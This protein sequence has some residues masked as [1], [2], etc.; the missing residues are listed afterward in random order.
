[1]MEE[2][3]ANIEQRLYSFHILELDEH[4]RQDGNSGDNTPAFESL[5]KMN[6]KP[7]PPPVMTRQK[8]LEM[9]ELR[10][11]AVQIEQKLANQ[12][13]LKLLEKVQGIV[14]GIEERRSS[15]QAS[16][17]DDQ[18][19]SPEPE[20]TASP[21]LADC[22]PTPDE[23]TNT[24]TETVD[25]TIYR[26][27]G[28][29]LS[30][31][32]TKAPQLVAN[33]AGG[34]SSAQGSTSSSSDASLLNQTVVAAS[35]FSPKD[36]EGT[37]HTPVD[38]TQDRTLT[39]EEKLCNHSFTED[40]AVS[41]ISNLSVP[42]RNIHQSDS[43]SLN[44][45]GR[46]TGTT[47]P[48][49]DKDE[50]NFQHPKNVTV[51]S[52]TS[53]G[54][55]A[56][57]KLACSWNQESR[58]IPASEERFEDENPP[59]SRFHL[60]PS[61]TGSNQDDDDD[62][63]PFGERETY[64]SLLGEYSSLPMPA[65]SSHFF[66][67]VSAAP[68]S[69][70]LDNPS[71]IMI[72]KPSELIGNNLSVKNP[73]KV[74]SPKDDESSMFISTSSTLL[75]NTAGLSCTLPSSLRTVSAASTLQDVDDP[76]NTLIETP[77]PT[78]EDLQVHPE[79]PR[80][81]PVGQEDSHG[82]NPTSATKTIK[83]SPDSAG[84]ENEFI[85][86]EKRVRRNSYTLD[87]PSPALLN[88]QARN[89][90]PRVN[91]GSEDGG[92][93]ARR[94]LELT[95]DSEIEING[96]SK[97]AEVDRVTGSGGQKI[98]LT[99]ELSE[100]NVLQQQLQ[101]FEE[102]RL[103][104]EQQQR[105]QLQQLLM[106]QQ[107]AQMTLQQEMAQLERR[108]QQKQQQQQQDQ[109]TSREED[110]AASR[111]GVAGR[112]EVLV[113]SQGKVSITSTAS[114]GSK[115]STP[116]SAKSSQHVSPDVCSKH[117]SPS[118]LTMV[119]PEV[120]STSKVGSGGQAEPFYLRG[121]TSKLA[122]S[123]GV[124]ENVA[125]PVRINLHNKINSPTMKKKF[126]K[127]SAVAKGYLT[128]RI[129]KTHRVQSIIKTIKDTVAFADKFISETPIKKG[130]MSM[131]DMMLAERVLAQVRAAQYD[132]YDIF[133]TLP[134]DERMSLLER[135][136]RLST[137]GGQITKVTLEPDRVPAKPLSAATVKALERK[138]KAKEAEARIFG[139]FKSAS[140]GRSLSS[141]GRP[142]SAAEGRILKPLVSQR[143]PARPASTNTYRPS[144]YGIVIGQ[145][146]PKSK[147]SKK[148]THDLS[149]AKVTTQRAPGNATQGVK[150][151]KTRSPVTVKTK[152][153][154]RSLYPI[155][156]PAKKAPRRTTDVRK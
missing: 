8:R 124:G 46:I 77:L 30:G 65:G 85:S 10:H 53:L 27:Q 63:D 84:S 50:T 71:P 32:G 4:S 87:H 90:A 62:L 38:M 112:T 61:L 133:F 148:L 100:E 11:E 41:S 135:N 89:E 17:V 44:P 132:L 143:S 75:T 145:D 5:I 78:Y 98:D 138:K 146:P 96:K 40:A 126:D 137:E 129:F 68:S 6:G 82:G 97:Q 119:S 72:E 35:D 69:T 95:K 142:A 16:Q 58:E 60:M 107:R 131:Q 123:P 92:S 7:I 109:A 113:E 36:R 26:D 33:P 14:N 59:L 147:D 76:W 31:L 29:S 117:T 45:A 15:S 105:E 106:E 42:G 130:G 81:T 151:T 99:E 54:S 136:K 13:R 12:R 101:Y 104:L 57:V 102:M 94:S 140:K 80:G 121:D 79:A 150:S 67:D 55:T 66:S 70:P 115:E 110:R 56:G 120:K 91:V 18:P 86:P 103:H 64:L 153:V 34:I 74:A 154:R 48:K 20:E 2:I 51:G 37:S 47:P 22:P 134:I 83:A 88:A 24:D 21:N 1:M 93:S 9:R 114:F 156:N 111:E 127:I 19:T 25:H 73:S 49:T 144:K 141:R 139:D 155:A 149:R 122:R 118:S 39:L 108:F 52:F 43:S 3:L 28:A 125:T 116:T 23:S 128:R 152:G